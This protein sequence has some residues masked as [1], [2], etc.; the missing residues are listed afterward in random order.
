MFLTSAGF[1]CTKIEQV[2]TR[3]ERNF[4]FWLF[5]HNVII[6]CPHSVITNINNI[7]KIKIIANITVAVTVKLLGKVKNS[8][9]YLQNIQTTNCKG[10]KPSVAISAVFVI[11]G[12]NN[13]SHQ[14]IDV[15]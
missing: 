5:F 14:L 13:F 4:K 10:A 6:E 3:E 2:R 9:S 7:T 8:G 12:T 15:T 1:W 11:D